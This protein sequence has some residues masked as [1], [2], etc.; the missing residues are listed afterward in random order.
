MLNIPVLL[1]LIATWDIQFHY[2][3]EP[4][5]PLVF[6]SRNYRQ[7]F[8][9]YDAM[10]S[11]RFVTEIHLHRTVNTVKQTQYILRSNKPVTNHELP[12]TILHKSMS[13]KGMA[14]YIYQMVSYLTL[15]YNV[16]RPQY[17]Y[18]RYCGRFE[19]I[20]IVVIACPHHIQHYILI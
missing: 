9:P 6:L 5:V 2:K 11:K 15:R 8:D 7:L 12:V 3:L 4:I 16:H 18:D 1:R 19:H 17:S 14:P 20:D 10:Y 13:L